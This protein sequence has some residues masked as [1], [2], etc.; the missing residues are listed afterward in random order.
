[1]EIPTDGNTGLIQSNGFDHIVVTT[2]E[3]F[4]LDCRTTLPDIEVKL[5]KNDEE[6]S[7]YFA[8]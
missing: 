2:S 7:G 5:F 3:K 4:V 8:I 6:V 1:M